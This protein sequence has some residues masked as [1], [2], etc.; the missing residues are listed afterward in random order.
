M[1]LK[2][3]ITDSAKLSEEEIEGII[4]D[5]VKYD[6]EHKAIVF[7]PKAQEL[8][9]EKKIL[10]HLVSLRGWRFVVEE[11]SPATDASP[12]EIE[13]VTG[14]RG[15]TLRPILRALAQSKMLNSQKGRYEI[16]AHNVGRV[17]AAMASGESMVTSHS[18][19]DSQ[20]N[21]K[22]KKVNKSTIKPNL[23][24]RGSKNKP[25]L[26]DSFE[27]LLQANWFR[28][29]KTLTQLKDRLE[30]MAVIVPMSHLPVH[31]LKACREENPRL[32]RNKETI[33]GKKIWV[34][35]QSKNE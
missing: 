20:S 18:K 23:Q 21:D 2:N 34:Y 1:P 33:N 6:P 30:E 26:A 10:L 8:S 25:S 14:V 17:R 27:K 5:F 7:L 35:S 16:P 9:A 32:K 29:G 11:N 4:A 31:L 13:R 19:Y 3:H 28:G 15:G 12:R 24:K 22:K